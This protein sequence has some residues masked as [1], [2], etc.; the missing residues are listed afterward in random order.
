MKVK[1]DSVLTFTRSPKRRMASNIYL[2]AERV[3]TDLMAKHSVFFEVTEG[4]VDSVGYA[5]GGLPQS[6]QD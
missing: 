6:Y 4:L 5:F 2:C 3:G 1:N